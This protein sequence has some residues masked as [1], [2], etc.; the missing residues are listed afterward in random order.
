MWG[1]LGIDT[2]I[3]PSEPSASLR[4]ELWLS[5]LLQYDYETLKNIFYTFFLVYV[6]LE[7][8]PDKAKSKDIIMRPI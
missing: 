8:L 1:I 4:I 3:Q 2:N 6:R 5:R 7:W